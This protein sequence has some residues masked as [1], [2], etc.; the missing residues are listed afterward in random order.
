MTQCNCC[1][2]ISWTVY[3]NHCVGEVGH[4]VEEVDRGQHQCCRF[5]DMSGSDRFGN[6]LRDRLPVGRT[7]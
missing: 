2:K 3:H 6:S 1:D 5:E 4:N 7:S